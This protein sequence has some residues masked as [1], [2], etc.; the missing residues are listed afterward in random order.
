MD[1]DIINFKDNTKSH[2]LHYTKN[3]ELLIYILNNGSIKYINDKDIYGLTPIFYSCMFNNINKLKTLLNYKA[4]INI[5][6]D[7]YILDKY[8]KNINVLHFVCSCKNDNLILFIL[9]NTNIDIY[10]INDV[11]LNAHDYYILNNDNINYDILH[12]LKYVKSNAK[13]ANK[14]YN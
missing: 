14:L 5:L 2:I 12:R 11:G 9:D 3:I 6:Y 8:I 7:T 1:Y 4:D 13:S 10:H